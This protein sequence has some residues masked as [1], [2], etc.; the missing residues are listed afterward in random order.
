MRKVGV[1]ELPLHWGKAPRW[2]FNRMVKLARGITK[3]IV[4]EYGED[5]LLKRLSNPFWFQAL[6]CVLGYDWHSSGTTTVT[7]AVLKAVSD[8]EEF[9]FG[10][11]GGKGKISRKTPEEIE[12]IS[13]I[14]NLSS[15]KIEKLKYASRMSAKVDLS[16]IHI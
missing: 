1:T 10:V 5:E 9:G 4:Y 2:L 12:K 7:T 13:E 16:L 15:K 11:A 14:F 8:P 3:I 6:A